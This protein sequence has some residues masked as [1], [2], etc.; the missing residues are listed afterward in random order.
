[1]L[2]VVFGKQVVDVVLL[3]LLPVVVVIEPFLLV[4]NIIIAGVGLRVGI[5][6]VVVSTS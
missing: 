3:G 1:M 6:V 2:I 5:I 4:V